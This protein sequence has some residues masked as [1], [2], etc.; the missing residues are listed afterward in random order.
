MAVRKR[1]MDIRK[2]H[3]DEM[4]FYADLEEG[5]FLAEDNSIL[6]Q[7]LM[8]ENVDILRGL[9]D[10]VDKRDVGKLINLYERIEQGARVSNRYDR[11]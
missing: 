8:E 5:I 10:Y 1:I 9:E 4:R 2:S 7:A 11:D 3:Y 6:P